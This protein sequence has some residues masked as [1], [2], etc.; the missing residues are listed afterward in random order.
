MV[1]QVLSDS[2]ENAKEKLDSSGGYVSSR[3]TTLLD[4]VPLLSE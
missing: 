2:E 1:I 4:S 3:T